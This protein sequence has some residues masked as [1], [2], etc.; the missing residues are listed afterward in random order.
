VVTRARELAAEVTDRW[1]EYVSSVPTN[2]LAKFSDVSLC[3]KEAILAVFVSGTR[4]KLA[5]CPSECLVPLICKHV[6]QSRPRI[7][8][9]CGAK[10]LHQNHRVIA[11][12]DSGYRPAD[13]AVF[14]ILR[15]FSPNDDSSRY[16]TAR[17]NQRA[18]L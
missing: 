3:E 4:D 1:Q 6:Q 11:A 9:S 12:A 15:L 8:R 10:Q 17:S 18:R 16:R 7:R 14:V 2:V 13:T 5:I